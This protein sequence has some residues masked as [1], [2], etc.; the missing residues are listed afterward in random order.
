MIKLFVEP[1]F[2]SFSYIPPNYRQ[3]VIRYEYISNSGKV[4]GRESTG[5]VENQNN[6][7]MHPPREKLFRIL[8]LSPFPYVKQ[9][10]DIT[11]TYNW[12]MMVGDQWGDSRWKTWEGGINLKF[13]YENTERKNI[14][15]EYNNNID[16]MVTES[17]GESTLGTTKLISYFNEELGFIKLEYT[18]IDGSTII[19][20]YQ[21]VNE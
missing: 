20:E 6:I 15:T 2:G 18:N 9:N 12:E 3:S 17:T 16:C 13:S 10:S 1:D 21:R 19:L 4:T 5:L 8:E 11:S 7:W 14:S